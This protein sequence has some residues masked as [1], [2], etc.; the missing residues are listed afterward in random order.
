LV[1]WSD[2]YSLKTLKNNNLHDICRDW[3][4]NG[5]LFLETKWQDGKEDDIE[6][7]WYENGQLWWVKHWKDGNLDGI[8]RTWYK[9]GQLSER[10]WKNGQQIYEKLIV[11]S[12]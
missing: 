5:Q 1:K 6:R 2:T 7:G 10:H 11:K 4:E 3:Y 8:D 9:N 12:S